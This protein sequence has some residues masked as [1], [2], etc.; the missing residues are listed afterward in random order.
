MDAASASS[1]WWL[2]RDPAVGGWGLFDPLPDGTYSPRP[3]MLDV[4][5]R[6]YA[7]AVG[8]TPESVVWDGATLTVTFDGKPGVPARHDLFWH[9]PAA[10][11]IRCDGKVTSPLTTDARGHVYT[12]ACGGG[13]R[14]VLT[15]AGNS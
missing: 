4:L 7:M 5:A 14:H 8:G 13:G 2:W 15:M 1:T 9:Q 11:V 10:P 3:A 6:P 12:V